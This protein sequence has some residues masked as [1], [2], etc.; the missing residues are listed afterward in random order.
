M[1]TQLKPQYK[2]VTPPI[3]TSAPTQAELAAN[4]ALITELKRQN[5][6]ETKAETDK[7]GKVLEALQKI[8]E[9]FVRVVSKKKNLPDS[10]IKEAGGKI[11]TYGSFRL[12]VFGPGKQLL[13]TSNTVQVQRLRNHTYRVRYRYARSCTQARRPRGFLRRLPTNP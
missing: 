7:R 4:D 5:N 6:Y 12:G 3:S 9:E 8:T 1:A 2:G 10:I 13:S 11:F